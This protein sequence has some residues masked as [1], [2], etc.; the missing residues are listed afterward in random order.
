MK[1]F[2]LVIILIL[3]CSYGYSQVYVAVNAQVEQ[4]STIS[5]QQSALIFEK[6]KVFPNKSQVSIA[7]IKNG[8]AVFY[9]VKRENDSILSCENYQR[10]FEIGSITKVFTSSLLAYYVIQKGLDLNSTINKSLKFPLKDGI[11][12]TFKQLANHTSGL[13]RL[14]SNLNLALVNSANPY[15]E[16]YEEKL[17]KYLTDDLKL[18]RNP[19]LKY[20]YSNL[21]VGLLAY[22][23]C[24]MEHTDYENLLVTKIFSRY[25]M[26]CSSTI[27]DKMKNHLVKGLNGDGDEVSNWDLSALVGAGGIL[28]TTEDLSKFVIAQFD[29]ANKELVLTRTKT[30]DITD[31]MGMGLG[32]H[33]IKAK[34]GA[35]WNWH[36]GGTGG[37][38]SSIA[39]DAKTKNGIVILSNVSAFNKNSGNIDQLCFELMNTLDKK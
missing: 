15:Q 6:S 4:K 28:S 37:Y 13:P 32:W 19:A 26:Y 35:D 3:A 20:E 9:G 7:V 21:G 17:K 23:L 18:S 12:I 36:N 34:S 27:R 16:Y 24:E 38:S 25:H 10:V 2:L 11:Q 5:E 39:I 8:V 22:V 31:K 30:F 33:I 29:C 1:K 14:P